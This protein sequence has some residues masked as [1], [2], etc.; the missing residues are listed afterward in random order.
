MNL[1]PQRL[2]VVGVVLGLLAVILLN[3]Y[4]GSVRAS[5]TKLPFLALKPEIGL[6][7]GEVLTEDMLR[8]V[9][10]PEGYEQLLSYA[11]PADARTTEWIRDRRVT[12]DVPAGSFLMHQHFMVDDAAQDRFA[13]TL[14]PGRRAVTIPVSHRTAV[15][16]FI[17]PGSRVDVLA[18]IER[19]VNEYDEVAVEK[20]GIPANLRD[21]MPDSVSK[22]RKEKVVL[23]KTILQ[24]VKI[25]AVDQARTRGNYLK[26]VDR[27]FR[28]VTVEATPLQAEA[29]VF[30][31]DHAA[32]ELTLVLRN[33]ADD[34]EAR[35]APVGWDSIE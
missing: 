12:Q 15:A 24:N 25:L 11:L 21:K 8:T 18:T 2:L 30:A 23:T 34:A 9:A 31:L 3:V 4:V 29:I 13:A 22:T 20:D 17:E 10:L 14:E 33:P 16:Y 19:E 32:G 28:T 1:N 35:I 27:G 5:Q 6:A 26:V 7:A